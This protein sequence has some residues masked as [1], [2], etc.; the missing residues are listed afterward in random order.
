MSRNTGILPI[1][2]QT[3]ILNV[4]T[5]PLPSCLII[6]EDWSVYLKKKLKFVSSTRLQEGRRRDK[7]C[8][9]RFAM[10]DTLLNSGSSL[11][12]NM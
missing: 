10:F 8:V 7:R 1:S 6:R 11:L 9:E 5:V 4:K 2:I 12:E 3:H